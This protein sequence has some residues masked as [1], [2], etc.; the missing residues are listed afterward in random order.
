MQRSA[1]RVDAGV[2]AIQRKIL[3]KRILVFCLLGLLFTSWLAANVQAGGLVGVRTIEFSSPQ[4]STPLKVTVWYP[5]AVG[6]TPALV[7]EDRL[8]R[9]TA[10]A[11]DA[12]VAPGRF[13]LLLVSHGSGGNVEGISWL[14]TRLAAAGFI[15]AGPNHPQTT[16]GNSTPIDTTKIWQRPA[17]LS[18]VLTALA[19]D[20]AWTSSLDASRVGAL[21]FSLGG[22][23]VMA[24][25]GARVSLEAYADYCDANPAMPDCIWF[26]SGHVDLRQTDRP[27]FE[28]SNRDA[29]IK[30]VVAIEPSIVQ[31]LTMESLAAVT[32]PVHLVNFRSDGKLL[33]GVRSDRVAAAIPGADFRI[34]E[35]AV[36]LSFLNECQAGGAAFLASVGEIDPLCN[37]ARGEPKSRAAIHAEVGTLIEAAFRRDLGP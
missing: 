12:P 4:R 25:A 5:A 6:G 2:H 37:D 35:D 13:P 11:L 27:L 18:A 3:T 9:G 24:L 7:G 33:F 21:G 10:A 1:E 8:F 30:S 31:A 15:V 22:H 36:H 28:Q 14:T 23:T 26:A 16:R 17:D 20:P 29:R 19:N 32:V 34:V